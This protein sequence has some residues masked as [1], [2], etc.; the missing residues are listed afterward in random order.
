M[1][2]FDFLS[3]PFS[4][5]EDDSEFL[6][7]YSNIAKEVNDYYPDF[8]LN[9]DPDS[10]NHY[11]DYR[12]AYEAGAKLDKEKHLPSEFKDDLHPDRYIVKEDMSIYDTKYDQPAKFEDLIVQSFNRREYEENFLK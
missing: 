8:T 4:P 7:W 6:D 11:Y 12:A 5:S 10:P 1:P 2:V 9:P 3:K